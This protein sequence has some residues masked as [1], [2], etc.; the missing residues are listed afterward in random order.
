MS[1]PFIDLQA[2]RKRIETEINTAIAKVV[3]HGGYILGPE[4]GQ[5]ERALA[6]FEDA[7]YCLACGNGT[8]ALVLPMMAWGIGPGDAVFCPSFTYTASAEAI[9]VIGATPVFV[10]VDPDTYTMCPKSLAEAIELIQTQTELTPKAVMAIDLFGQIADYPK[11]APIAKAAGLHLISDCAQGTG[12]R[13][14]GDSPLKWADVVTTSFFPAKPLGCYGDGGAVLTN[15]EELE[16]T[17]RSLAFHGRSDVPYDYDK[18]GINSRLDTIQA[19]ILL[20]KLKIFPSE[21]KE[22]NRLADRYSKALSSN[23]I[24]TPKIMDGCVSTWAQYTVETENRDE[25]MAKI[26]AQNVPVAAYYPMPVHR[27]TAYTDYPVAPNGLP[28]T[29]QIMNTVFSLPMHAYL[30]TK[31][32][33]TIIA[34]VL[35]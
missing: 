7:K 34:A 16:K 13:L 9:A 35:S 28:V 3:E 2:Q 26:K 29:E 14:F 12:T 11:L 8:D 31:D 4:V 24:K 1:I 23:T 5:F 32:Q 10:D 17:M 22:R 19:A 30:T 25:I 15:D 6:K 20:E 18:I 21:I 27:Q 33:D